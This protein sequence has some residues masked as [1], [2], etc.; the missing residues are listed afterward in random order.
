[1]NIPRFIAGDLM[2]ALLFTLAVGLFFFLTWVYRIEGRLITFRQRLILN[3]IRVF[4]ILLVLAM[5]ARPAVKIVLIEEKQPVVAFLI[6]NSTS[7]NYPAERTNPLING[8]P[9]ATRRRIDAAESAIKLLAPSISKTHDLKLY[10]F[11]DMLQYK[12][13]IAEGETLGD[14]IP[15]E[16]TYTHIGDALGDLMSDLQQRRIASICILS[17]GRQTGGRKLEEIQKIALQGDVKIHTLTFG[18]EFPLRDLSLEEVNAPP[19]AS[20]GDVLSL[21]LRIINQIEDPLRIEIELQEEGKTILKRKVKLKRGEN[22]IPLHTI[23][24]VEGERRYK[25]I[26]PILEDEIDETNNEAEIVVKVVKRTLRVLLIAGEPNREYHYL[27]PALLRD[28]IIDMSTFLQNSDINYVQQGNHSIERLPKTTKEWEAY[29][30]VL[31][32]DIDP[33]KFTPQQESGLEH[34]VNKGGGLMVI[35]GRNFGLSRLLQVHSAKM[36]QLLPVEIEKTRFPDYDKILNKPITLSLTP[37]GMAHPILFLAT[38]PKLNAKIW[39]TLPKFYWIHPVLNLKP[40]AVSLLENKNENEPQT[41]MAIHRYGEG[42]V[43]YLGIS[44]L[45]RWRFPY[46]SYDYDRLWTRAIRYLGETRLKGMQ[47]QVSL[48]SDKQLYAPGERIRLMLRILDPA[49]L[50]QLKGQPIFASVAG[51]KGDSLMVT[52]RQSG[53]APLFEGFTVARNVGQILTKVRQIAPNS[54]SEAKPLFEIKHSFTV[55]MRSLEQVDTRADLEGMKALAESTGG[56]FYSYREMSTLN[57]LPS[58]ISTEPQ[59]I[60]KERIEEVWD[61]ITILI[62]FL[63]LASFEWAL[64]KKW[65]LL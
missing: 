25:V 10:T 29:D 36:R 22:S 19:D 60:R 26:L 65:R 28:P 51:A 49:L 8:R 46:G 50:V 59:I 44:S 54:D 33:T 41:A 43:L 34:L 37:S 55:N 12:K 14:S 45:W 62:L 64:R 35:A 5:I 3:S 9:K 21:H 47:K 1:M 6:D 52:L 48:S 18:S 42:A 24:T 30:V 7:M 4:L 61:S 31:L 15:T 57:E 39:D 2:V 38:D 23:P 53:K 11:S 40:G 27:V 58:K 32:S 56:E 20:L 63:L 13:D 17:D 16:G